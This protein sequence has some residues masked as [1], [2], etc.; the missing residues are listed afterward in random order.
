ML[1]VRCVRNTVVCRTRNTAT[2]FHSTHSSNPD[3]GHPHP[4]EHHPPPRTSTGPVPTPPPLDATVSG[5]ASESC[6]N[7][8]LKRDYES[9]LT[10]KF[11]LHDAQDGFFAL[12]AFYVYTL[13][14]RSL[15]PS[16]ESDVVFWFVGGGRLSWR[17]FKTMLRSP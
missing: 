1:R 12:K 14:S 15:S 11:Y 7:L 2:R 6:R 10:S 3:H 17:P 13:P 4:H 5:S 9:F 8:V 16:A